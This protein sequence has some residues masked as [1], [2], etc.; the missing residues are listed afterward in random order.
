MTDQKQ[1]PAPLQEWQRDAI[2]AEPR[3]FMRDV[4]RDAYH[5]ISQS[6]SLIPERQRSEED[7]PRPPSGGTVEIKAPPGINYVDQLCDAA[8]RNDRIAAL[9]AKV[10]NDWIEFQLEQA[11]GPRIETEYDPFSRQ[12][13]DD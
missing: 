11:K 8:D 7:T 2:R 12:R 3:G 1:K 6:A 10:E 9:R 13:M 5:G 4:I